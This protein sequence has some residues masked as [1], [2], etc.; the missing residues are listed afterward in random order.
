LQDNVKILSPNK[1]IE[2][3]CPTKSVDY[4]NNLIENNQLEKINEVECNIKPKKP[5]L[6]RGTGLARY[7][8]NLEEVKKASGKL[9]FHKPKIPVLPKINMP[10]KCLN[11][12][13]K[14][15]HTEFGK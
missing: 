4:E 6:K 8:L 11:Q 10:R 2:K 1:N 13:L 14:F 3:I 12:V 9:K 5:Y 7:G 15:P